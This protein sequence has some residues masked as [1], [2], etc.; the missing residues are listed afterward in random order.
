MQGFLQIDGF[1]Y[2][3]DQY[4]EEHPLK[5]IPLT[6]SFKSI[7]KQR[8]FDVCSDCGIMLSR[9]GLPN[10]FFT[11][12]S[13]TLIGSDVH[14]FIA[15]VYIGRYL[16]NTAISLACISLDLFVAGL[17]CRP[18]AEPG[19]SNLAARGSWNLV[20]I[21]LSFSGHMLGF[22]GRRQ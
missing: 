13:P 12:T 22:S 3:I 14:V 17:V 7:S 8:M 6:L 9:F 18:M 19:G 15:F 1:L 2:K 16:Y 20:G 11:P 4:V 5:Y 21:M 10:P